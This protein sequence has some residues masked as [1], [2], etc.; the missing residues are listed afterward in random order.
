[1]SHITTKC[2]IK[3]LSKVIRAGD[4]RM[5]H[6][7]NASHIG[8][9]LSTNQ[10]ALKCRRVLRATPSHPDW[11]ERDRSLLG[12]GHGAGAVSTVKRVAI[13]DKSAEVAGTQQYLRVLRRLL[14]FQCV[15]GKVN[16]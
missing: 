11:P 9:W 7:A 15:R 5:V 1:M 6:K 4:L 16:S 3:H 10:H 8:S 14:V 13:P 2:S 12:K